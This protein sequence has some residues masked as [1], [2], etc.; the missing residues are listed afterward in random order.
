[1]D[2]VGGLGL[3][4]PAGHIHTPDMQHFE[5]PFR[6]SD[7]TFDAWRTAIVAQAANLIHVVADNAGG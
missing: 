5:T 4:I 6:P 2:E 1:M 3:H 7:P